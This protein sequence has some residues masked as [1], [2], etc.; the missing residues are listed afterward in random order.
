MAERFASSVEQ[1]GS[2]VSKRRRSI[3]REKRSG[4]YRMIK[5]QN[6]T[7]RNGFGLSRMREALVPAPELIREAVE[8]LSSV[9]GYSFRVTEKPVVGT[10][11]Y[12]VY[13]SD[14]HFRPL[15]TVT[16]GVL[17]FRVP[18][19]Y[20]DACPEDSFF[21]QPTD[22]KLN[23]ADPV[24]NSIDINRAGVAPDFLSGSGLSPSSALVFSWHL[25][26]R[27][28]WNRNL[29]SLVDH[30]TH[31]VRRFESPEHDT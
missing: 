13:A 12:V 5:I 26:N 19:N 6:C 9:S 28:P 20:P 27:R 14:H 11:L 8:N 31:C 25:W 15:Y 30:Y 18:E 4:Q 24:R 3:L 23:A 22:I 10:T 2:T 1:T 16:S 7:P 21:I 17:G 29:H